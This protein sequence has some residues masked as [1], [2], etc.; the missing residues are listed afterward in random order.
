MHSFCCSGDIKL[1]FDQFTDVIFN[2]TA[3]DM[4][5]ETLLVPKYQTPFLFHTGGQT[6]HSKQKIYQFVA[7]EDSHVQLHPLHHHSK[8]HSVRECLYGGI[9][10]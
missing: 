9:V 3:E 2:F 5:V 8:A 10:I 1:C 6:R 7:D 4:E